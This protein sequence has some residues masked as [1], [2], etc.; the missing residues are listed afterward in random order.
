MK[1]GHLRWDT[2]LRLVV[3]LSTKM[4]MA[5][6]PVRDTNL[7]EAI[8]QAEAVIAA[9]NKDFVNAAKDVSLVFQA[10]RALHEKGDE[11]RAAEYFTKGLQ[12]SPWS[13]EEQLVYAEVLRKLKRKEE[14]IEIG[15][16][17]VK[18]AE[19]DEL[20]NA[21]L[22]MLGRGPVEGPSVFKGPVEGPW[23]CFIKVGP[24]EDIVM[25]E[26]MERISLTLGMPA[27]LA[28]DTV[29]LPAADRSALDRWVTRQVIPGIK[30]SHPVARQM[31]KDLGG[32]V[33]TD[34][35]PKKL[36]RGLVAL[37]RSEGEDVR[38]ENMEKEILHFEKWD[39]QWRASG[40]LKM[41]QSYLLRTPM[42]GN[43]TVVGVTGAD[44]CDDDVNFLFGSAL[45]GGKLAVTSYARYTAEFNH[46]PP[47][48]KKVLSRLHKQLLSGIGY[49]LGVPRPTDPTSARAY[50]ASLAEH[51]AKS[52]YMSAACRSG[53]EKALG[54][55]LPMEAIPPQMR[56]PLRPK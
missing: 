39:K 35:A 6:L 27:Y 23:L 31:L 4:V 45:T 9:S 2:L 29:G 10:A 46:G 52:E 48:R 16:M 18:R 41:L 3:L 7:D 34:I 47:E 32:E 12:L 43:V 28:P 37:M 5:Q 50:P 13:L 33:P 11:T 24:V 54:R 49:A 51:D 22:K 30:W 38:A 26:A 42:P 20:A 55:K 19:T 1:K 36:L 21:A 15:E 53:F 56:G 44:L 17:V 8:R 25:K 40:L 14:A